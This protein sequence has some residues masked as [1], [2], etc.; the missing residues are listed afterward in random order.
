MATFADAG[1]GDVLETTAFLNNYSNV[2]DDE[3]SIQGDKLG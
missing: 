1:N 2:S 3:D